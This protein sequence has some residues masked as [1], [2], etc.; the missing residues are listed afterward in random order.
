M[1]TFLDTLA[2]GGYSVSDLDRMPFTLS[3]PNNPVSL[4]THMRGVVLTSLRAA[5]VLAEFYSPYYLIDRDVLLA[6]A[7]LHDVAKVLEYIET[8][9]GFIQSHVG[10]LVRHPF[11]GI[12]QKHG[13][14]AE[15]LHI[16]AT[17]SK[18]GDLQYRSPVAMIVYY[19]GQMNARPLHDVIG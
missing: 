14:P 18:E 12:A 13:L 17:H 4:L 3:I 8:E 2:L 15:V 7:I 9:K 19:A 1:D 11:A 16:I 6:G 10:K 5:E